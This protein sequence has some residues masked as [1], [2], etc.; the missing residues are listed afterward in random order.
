MG[1]APISI[2]APKGRLDRASLMA[3]ARKLVAASAR[4]WNVSERTILAILATPFVVAFIGLV[5]AAIGKGVYKWVVADDKIGETVQVV[6]YFTVLVLG[7]VVARRFWKD[8]HTVIMSLYLLLC[9][10]LVFLVGEELSWGQRIFHWATPASLE[11]VNKQAESN[12]HNISSVE[13]VF[14]WVQLLI[15]AYG[16]VFPVLFWR[17]RWLRR[18]RNTIAA[19][20]PHYA[21][22][23]CFFL[24]FI[25]R[26][27]R[28]LAEPPASF[29]FV[30]SEY[31]E[32]LEVI[33]S[34][35]LL[36][37]MVFQVKRTRERRELVVPP[38]AVARSS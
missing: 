30:V 20:V 1:E 10:G 26:V 4:D 27:Y 36:L 18:Y 25:W 29:H 31:N 16:T 3:T 22:V 33:L 35:A 21:L 7:L 19:L 12:L 32:I 24:L 38:E 13:N 9:L 6:L 5:T 34:I 11:R 2:I 28:N 15:G 14:K 17:S 37:F 8:G 23:P